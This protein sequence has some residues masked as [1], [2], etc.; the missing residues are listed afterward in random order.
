MTVLARISSNVTCP[1]RPRVPVVASVAEV[2]GGWLADHYAVR[3][4]LNY[5]AAPELGRQEAHVER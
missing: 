5:R 1:Q 2:P 4:F 3:L